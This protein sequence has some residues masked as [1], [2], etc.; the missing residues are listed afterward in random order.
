LN[1]DSIA[2]GTLEAVEVSDYGWIV[3]FGNAVDVEEILQEGVLVALL[4]SPV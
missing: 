1:S 2:G 3:L 4:E